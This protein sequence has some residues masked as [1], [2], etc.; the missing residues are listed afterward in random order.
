MLV[1]S[2]KQGCLLIKIYSTQRMTTDHCTRVIHPVNLILRHPFHLARA[3]SHYQVVAIRASSTDCS[4]V[5]DSHWAH[6]PTSTDAWARRKSYLSS[7]AATAASLAEEAAWAWARCELA[8]QKNDSPGK[9]MTVLGNTTFTC[10][11][12]LFFLHL[13]S[14]TVISTLVSADSWGK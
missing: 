8:P 6:V 5:K 9:I 1:F 3:S 11:F 14:Y 2:S 4:E 13:D 12:L 10:T 7:M